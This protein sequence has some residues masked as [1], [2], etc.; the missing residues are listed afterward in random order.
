MPRKNVVVWGAGQI[1]RG[2]V[3]DLFT[4]AGYHLILVGR[5]PDLIAQLRSAGRYTVVKVETAGQR[6]DEVIAG[7]TAL[8]TAQVNELA[9]AVSAA[10]SLA[11]AVYPRDFSTV[12]RQLVPGLLR[13]HTERPEAALDILLCANLPQAAAKFRSLLWEALPLDAHGYAAE[14]IGVVGTIVMRLAVEPPPD[15]QEKGPL[16]VWT[17]GFEDFPVDRH[18]F[19]GDIPQIPGLR[20]VDDIRTEELRKLYTNNMCHAA[21]AY[22]G[23]LRGHTLN[24]DCA[25]DPWVYAEMEGA[26]GEVNQALQAEYGFTDSDTAHWTKR[27]LIRIGNP[28]V[29]DKVTRIAGDPRRK[30]RREDRLVGPALLARRHGIRPHHLAR[31]IAAALLFQNP[32]D[33]G[34]IY[35]RERVAEM[36]LPPAVREVCGLTAVE[37]DLTV[38]IVEAYYDLAQEAEH[39][40]S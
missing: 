27:V 26:L 39:T 16:W 10:D 13:R 9:T 11:V 6:R 24:T 33:P 34:A 23:A 19:R 36:R 35:V 31:V 8:T 25:S 15:V 37:D 30:L 2:Y 3:A 18:A 7:Y 17:D 12:A 38:M 29:S 28:V 1:G 14:R 5:S 22:L 32:T 4:A 20:L 21:L 40:G